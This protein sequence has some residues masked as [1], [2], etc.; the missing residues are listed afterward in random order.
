MRLTLVTLLLW[1][2]PGL[3]RS[4]TPI[5]SI[6]PTGAPNPDPVVRLTTTTVVVT[7]TITNLNGGGDGAMESQ[8]VVAGNVTFVSCQPL[9]FLGE[10]QVI[11]R[12]MTVTTT[13]AGTGAITYRVRTT[14]PVGAW[15]E[16]TWNETIVAPAGTVTPDAQP[17]MLG[18]GLAGQTQ[19]FTVTNTSSAPTTFALSF[20]CPNP[21]ATGCT[22]SQST[23][24]LAASGQSGSTGNV[25]VTFTT[26]G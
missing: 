24:P 8:C 6:S 17:L 4:Q 5:P 18:P 21:G 19:V 13:G 15:V 22:L 1:A 3:L 14:S 25:T 26:G 9:T 23:I 20:A 16:G 10:A 12:T 7:F 11:A 2:L